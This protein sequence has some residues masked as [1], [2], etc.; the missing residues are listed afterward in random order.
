MGPF[1]DALAAILGRTHPQSG[2]R[3][4]RHSRCG[5]IRP[6]AALRTSVG[7]RTREQQM[8]KILGGTVGII[9]LIGLL[10]VIG[11]LSLIF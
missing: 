5:N 3:I 6:A 4:C 7:K 10:V 11:I 2:S 9:F 8:L 1:R